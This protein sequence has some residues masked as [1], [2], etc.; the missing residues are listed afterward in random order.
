MRNAPM[1]YKNPVDNLLLAI[2]LQAVS[3][4]DDKRYS[5]SA[6]DFLKTDGVDIYK[7]LKQSPCVGDCMLVT[8]HYTR[9]SK[10]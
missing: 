9:P 7:H 10:K 3:D 6:N 2:L 4:L 1:R 5:D 8:N